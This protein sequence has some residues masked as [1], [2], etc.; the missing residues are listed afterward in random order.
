LSRFL[1]VWLQSFQKV[2][3][4]QNKIF[5]L[6]KKAIKNRQNFTLISDPLKKSLANAPKESYIYAKQV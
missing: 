4:W 6:I 3:I 1:R 5:F 2:L